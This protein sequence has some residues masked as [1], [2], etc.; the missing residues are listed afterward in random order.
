MERLSKTEYALVL[1]RA[2]ALRSTCP[3]R[4]VGAVLLKEGR[5]ISTGYNGAPP[6]QVDCLEG[7]CLMFDGHCINTIHAEQNALLRARETG[8]VLV[9]TDQPCLSCL[10]AAL[11]HNP[12]IHIYAWRP[13][14]DDARTRFIRHH[15]LQSLFSFTEFQLSKVNDYII[16]LS[17]V[18]DYVKGMT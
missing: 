17:R 18:N 5:I 12:G 4:Q 8:D 13:Y 6:G 16:E 9:S 7:G 1:A 11:S 3:R 15:D 2:A 10:K 14:I